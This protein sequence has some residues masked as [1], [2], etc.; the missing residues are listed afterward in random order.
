MDR[1]GREHLHPHQPKCPTQGA[2]TGINRKFQRKD[3]MKMK[4]SENVNSSDFGVVAVKMAYRRETS[5][6]IQKR[7]LVN[8]LPS[9]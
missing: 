7:D 8:K 4:T 3:G 5:F 6:Q 2:P 9:L 1:R